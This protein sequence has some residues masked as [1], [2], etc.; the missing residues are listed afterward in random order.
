M[1][2]QK[3]IMNLSKKHSISMERVCRTADICERYNIKPTGNVFRRTPEEIEELVKIC[4]SVNINPEKSRTVF[5]Q[6]PSAI[7]EIIN[8]CNEHGITIDPTIF[9]ANPKKMRESIQYIESCFGSKY[10]NLRTAMIDVEKL[11][12]SMPTLQSMGLLPYTLYN[13][14]V[15]ELSR[16]EIIERAGVLQYLGIPVHVIGSKTREDKINKVFNL[17]KKSYDDYCYIHCVNE[18]IRAFYKK[19]LEERIN[20]LEQKRKIK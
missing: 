14:N 10:V 2:S 16:D 4:K 20:E 5:S 9:N 8:I 3:M 12:D 19:R 7:Q 18:K 11:R 6:P 17:S 1:L 15:F 13:S